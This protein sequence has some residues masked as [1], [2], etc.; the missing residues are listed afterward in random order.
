MCILCLTLVLCVAC[1]ALQRL[2]LVLPL[3]LRL[4]GRAVSE[5]QQRQQPA[6]L[7]LVALEQPRRSLL[8]LGGCLVQ[9]QASLRPVAVSALAAAAHLPL[10]QPAPLLSAVS[11]DCTASITSKSQM[12]VIQPGC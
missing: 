10:A 9:L 3:A 6:H 12:A 2:R 5:Q 1:C 7:L 8:L 4:L 11:P